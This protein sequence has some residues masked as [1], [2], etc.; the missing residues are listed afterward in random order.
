ML[1]RNFFAPAIALATLFTATSVLAASLQ[2]TSSD[3]EQ[4]GRTVAA[5]Q[6][7]TISIDGKFEDWQRVRPAARTR[8]SSPSSAPVSFGQVKITHDDEFV[9]LKVDLGRK[10]NPQ[11]LDGRMIL[12]LDVDG[13]ESTGSAEYGVR[14]ADL[15]IEFT[16]RNTRHP[17]RPGMGVGLRSTTLEGGGRGGLSPYDLS[18]AFAPTY[19]SEKIEMRLERRVT[20]PG[21]PKTFDGDRFIGQFVL[22]DTEG[23][24][25]HNTPA[26]QYR[27]TETEPV[28]IKFEDDPLKRADGTDVRVVS[29][30]AEHG[31]LIANPDPFAR[32]LKALDP[33]V[34]L[35]QE[36]TPRN[37]ASQMAAFMNEH[38]P[39]GEG[40]QW[41]VVFGEG[42]GPL[43]CA[44]A[45]R[46]PI[47]HVQAVDTIPYPN[48]PDR[49]VRVAGAAITVGDKELL[50]VTTHLKC[51]GA[52]NT[53]EDR[54]RMEEVQLINNAV[55]Q[56]LQ[57]HDFDG[58]IV[59]GDLNLVGERE[60]KLVLSRGI[61][62][63]G[64]NLKTTDAYH[65]S[66]RMNATW[67]ERRSQFTPGRLDFLLFSESTLRAARS[68][69]LETEEVPAKWLEKHGMLATDTT[70]A[71]DHF[72][73][74]ADYIW[75]DPRRN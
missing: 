75:Q 56:A 70:T 73:V 72:P 71:T 4:D 3:R 32:I 42:G 62:P 38:V 5:T 37:S 26:F 61:A 16:P 29:W 18:F 34:V 31:S 49:Q 67:S 43:R 55:R 63:D 53:R 20:V 33:D 41:R 28:E 17:D 46:L 40:K 21:S 48:R 52:M 60:P 10:V 64:S 23:E 45:S 50:A 44:I 35:W 66:G 9:Y 11:R 27:L 22:V 68:F 12:A 54:Q 59:G 65:L 74:V 57:G 25:V 58:V 14:G 6:S 47:R 19:A 36:L 51:C 69:V 7:P 2:S 8:G 15:L 39:A 24:V 13:D 1:E 30:N